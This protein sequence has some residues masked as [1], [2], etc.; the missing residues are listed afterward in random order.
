MDSIETALE[1]TR[2]LADKGSLMSPVEAAVRILGCELIHSRERERR[3]M[4]Q[5]QLLT[6][7][8]EAMVEAMEQA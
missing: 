5:N 3:L 4:V 8:V 7:T 2:S 1:M 6:H